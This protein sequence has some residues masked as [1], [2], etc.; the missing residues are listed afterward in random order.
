MWTDKKGSN[1]GG[2]CKLAYQNKWEDFYIKYCTGSKLPRGH[3]FHPTVQPIYEALTLILAE[4][5][6]IEV[7]KYY[8][9]FNEGVEFEYSE[10]NPK[11]KLDVNKPMYFLSKLVELPP[12]RDPVACASKMKEEIIYQK[13]LMIADLSNKKQNYAYFPDHVP[14][15]ILYIDVGCNFVDAISGYLSQ[16][17]EVSDLLRNRRGSYLPSVKKDLKNAKKWLK[18]A[19]ILT[20]HKHSNQKELLC[21]EDFIGAIPDYEIPKFPYGHIKMSQVLRED[22][23]EEIMSLLRL[24]MASIGRKFLKKGDGRLFFE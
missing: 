7:P 13:L 21:L 18:R 20:N 23:L 17:N 5:M 8:V 3:P 1:P 2:K 19:H 14:P 22:E 16:R 9:L 12:H 6:G 11:N 10:F 24:N 15:H 4:G